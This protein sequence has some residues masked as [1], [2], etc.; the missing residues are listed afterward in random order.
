MI[1]RLWLLN[2]NVL[3]LLK[4]Q[5]PSLI[6]C[7]KRCL[8]RLKVQS[9]LKKISFA[10]IIKRKRVIFGWKIFLPNDCRFMSFVSA[11]YYD[12]K[13]FS[14]KTIFKRTKKFKYLTSATF[15][16]KSIEIAVKILFKFFSFFCSKYIEDFIFIASFYFIGFKKCKHEKQ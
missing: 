16:P 11:S 1:M 4:K 15:L 13:H 9:F 6:P 10:F 5:Q 12:C 7:K 2:T 14:L 3:K 8:Y